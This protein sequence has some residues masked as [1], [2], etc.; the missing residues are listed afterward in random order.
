MIFGKLLQ[1][2]S[3]GETP[4]HHRIDVKTLCSEGV[5]FDHPQKSI[6]LLTLLQNKIFGLKDFFFIL[7]ISEYKS[8]KKKKQKPK[9]FFFFFLKQN[10]QRRF[11]QCALFR[12]G[13]LANSDSVFQTEVLMI[14]TH[15]WSL[16]AYRREPNPDLRLAGAGADM[17]LESLEQH[18]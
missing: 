3:N 11:S 15:L 2:N 17:E 6:L 16:A 1:T 8:C 18:P 13:F 10:G 14:Q 9:M 5:F 4:A 12:F 7:L